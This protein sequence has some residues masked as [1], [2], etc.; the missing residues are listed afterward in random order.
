MTNDNNGLN[1]S[2]MTLHFIPLSACLYSIVDLKFSSTMFARPRHSYSWSGYLYTYFYHVA[3]S[4]ACI[5]R[6]TGPVK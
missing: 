5:Q 6:T 3:L 1:F 2:S 4:Q